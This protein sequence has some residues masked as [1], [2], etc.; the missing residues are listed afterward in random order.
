MMNALVVLRHYFSAF[1]LLGIT[2]EIQPRPSCLKSS[3]KFVVSLLYGL[4][5]IFCI[6]ASMTIMHGMKNE[7]NEFWTVALFVL[8]DINYFS[9]LIWTIW[10]NKN[11]SGVI[12]SLVSTL[13]KVQVNDVVAKSANYKVKQI[14]KF[15]FVTKCI[16]I[17][18]INLIIISRIYNRPEIRLDEETLI[19]FGILFGL[20]YYMYVF[21]PLKFLLSIPSCCFFN[22]TCD[23]ASA[24]FDE[25]RNEL[26]AVKSPYRAR[27]LIKKSIKTYVDLETICKTTNEMFSIILFISCV[28]TQALWS[29]IV[30][31]LERDR[32]E[33]LLAIAVLIGAHHFEG[34]AT[35]ILTVST[36]ISA[37]KTNLKRK[38]L[39]L[40]M[41]AHLAQQTTIPMELMT[42]HIKHLDWIQR[43]LIADDDWIQLAWKIP[44]DETLFLTI[45]QQVVAFVQ[46]KYTKEGMGLDKRKV[47]DQMHSILK[48]EGKKKLTDRK[49]GIEEVVE[50]VVVVAVDLNFCHFGPQLYRKCS[51]S[52]KNDANHKRQSLKIR[53]G[54]YKLS[55]RTQKERDIVVDRVIIHPTFIMSKYINDLALLHL[56]EDI[57][58]DDT[59]QPICLPTSLNDTMPGRDMTIAGWGWLDEPDSG[60]TRSNILQKLDVISIDQKVC[61]GWYREAGKLIV[62]HPNHMCAGF[63]EGGKDSCQG[64]SGGPLMWKDGNFY[65]LVGVVSAGIGCGRPLLPGLYTRV[66]P[67]LSWIETNTKD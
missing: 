19:D 40:A 2:D 13:R 64:D 60:G 18:Y 28:T 32:S 22:S 61:Q 1:Q 25:I 23:L 55:E 52:R 56:S 7:H 17:A 5:A 35:F 11:N 45:F 33:S 42:D 43:Q 12:K 34:Y 10:I 37:L 38:W 59:R 26:K 53:V 31:I 9:T 49:T 15:L 67:Y 39:T 6:I 47:I 46:T 44:I 16:G 14:F 57:T 3:A 24:K 63:K 62:I 51:T 8:P 4:E 36:L 41:S 27:K 50:D 20:F 65:K 30:M 66:F 21:L 54:E 58:W 48:K 29:D